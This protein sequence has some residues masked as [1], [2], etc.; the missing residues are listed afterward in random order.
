MNLSNLCFHCTFTKIPSV[1]WMLNGMV[2]TLSR[3]TGPKCSIV[4]PSLWDGLLMYQFWSFLLQHPSLHYLVPL[5]RWR[6]LLEAHLLGTFVYTPL[7]K[8]RP[9]SSTCAGCP[10][11]SQV[12]VG[13]KSPGSQ[14]SQREVGISFAEVHGKQ[15]KN[16]SL[17]T[18]ICLFCQR[19]LCGLL[20]GRLPAWR[21]LCDTRSTPTPRP[22]C[23]QSW[24]DPPSFA[25]LP[26]RL[27]RSAA[28][29]AHRLVE[30]RFSAELGAELAARRGWP[31]SPPE[32]GPAGR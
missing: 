32:L 9:S 1:T 7:S 5:V 4:S 3:K 15:R 24:A 6:D 31:A 27:L 25:A 14:F 26:S 8:T 12:A 19:S 20:S 29:R 13:I 16:V 28:A 17:E 22:L 21:R 10:L 18:H 11:A 30:D 23:R 2:S